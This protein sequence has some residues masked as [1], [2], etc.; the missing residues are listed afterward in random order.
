MHLISDLYSANVCL[1]IEVSHFDR[2]D[3]GEIDQIIKGVW[4]R[5]LDS[6]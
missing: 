6:S 1:Q 2:I 4:C 5:W 3:L